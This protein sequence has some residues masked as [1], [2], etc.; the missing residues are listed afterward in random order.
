MSS[1]APRTGRT[2]RF[3]GIGPAF[4]TAALVFG[5]GSITTASS[6]GASFGYELLWTP[7]LA[8]ILML[9]F[10]DVSVRIGLSTDRGAVPTVSRRF[11]R[12]VGILVA[13]GAML[14]VTSFQ[15]GNSAGAGAAGQV[16]FGGHSWLW[17]ALFTALAIGLLWMPSF[18]RRLETTMVVIIVVMLVVFVLTALVSRPDLG[19]VVQGLVPR[20]PTGSST[21]VVG[22]VATTFS[23]VGAFYQIQLIR[24]KG[25]G[26]ADY[27]RARRDA[28]TG[29][30]I[31]GALSFVIM[32][33][34][35]AVLHPRGLAVKSPVD[36][37][38]ILTPTVGDWASVLFALGLWAAAFSSLIGNGSI[39]GT[40]LAAVANRDSGG[41][42]STFVKC[43]ITAVMILGGG[44]AI[45]FGGIPV[46]L[47][48]TA[49]AV[50]IFIAPLIGLVLIGL[51]RHRDRGTLRIA[52]PQLFL[53]LLGVGFLF[54]LALTYLGRFL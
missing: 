42:D 11:G 3:A 23:V 33:A 9:C 20:V 24:E 6:M 19:Q 54:V 8:T 18:Y 35:A 12:V 40:M 22:S 27:R 13:V 21:L 49:Q 7:V 17:T 2:G 34:A 43:C 25:W 15:A 30:C 52:L 51:A 31:L 46:Q 38:S 4:V 14:V 1:A 26:A 47:I 36:M 48:I 28:I 32:V 5:P 44:V 16:L 37:A 29:S 53:S 39:G 50:T 10:V 45:G 41:L